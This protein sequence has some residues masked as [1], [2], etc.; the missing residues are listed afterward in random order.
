M[1]TCLICETLLKDPDQPICDSLFCNKE[2][3]KRLKDWKVLEKVLK[4][5]GC[6]DIDD[7]KDYI[8]ELKEKRNKLY[9]ELEELRRKQEETNE[10]Q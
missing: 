2:T 6:R 10:S 8:D 3:R 1:T 4:G 9:W 5:Y 7:L